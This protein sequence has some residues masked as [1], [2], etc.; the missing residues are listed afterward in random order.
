MYRVKKDILFYIIIALILI[1]ALS[2]HNRIPQ[3]IDNV[4]TN[5][6]HILSFFVLSLYLDLFKKIKILNVFYFVILFGLSIEITQGLFTIRQFDLFDVVFDIIGFGLSL[7]V[8]MLKRFFMHYNNL[9]YD[10]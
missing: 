1:F 5:Y 10:H 9:S 7:M 6:L 2:P 3:T 4:D 8:L